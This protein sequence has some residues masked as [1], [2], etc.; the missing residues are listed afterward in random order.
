MGRPHTGETL[1][2]RL[3]DFRRVEAAEFGYPF[4][5]PAPGE[6]VEGLLVMDL[7]A[8]DLDRLDH[9]E[10]AADDLYRRVAVE[11]EVFSCGSRTSLIASHTYIGGEY[12]QRL[13]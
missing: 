8:A 1:R 11:V 13:A 9:Y 5:V 12:L 10:D 7:S 4:L 6:V 2:A 3:A